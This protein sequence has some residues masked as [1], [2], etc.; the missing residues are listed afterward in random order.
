MDTTDTIKKTP[1]GPVV[2][3]IVILVIIIVGGVYFWGQRVRTVTNEATQNSQ[4]DAQT[5]SLN[6]QGFTD[7]TTS[8]E[9]DLNITNFSN[10]DSGSEQLQ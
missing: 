4:Q 7:E 6:T 10:I 9:S 5:E 8:I 3:L 2:G 1:F